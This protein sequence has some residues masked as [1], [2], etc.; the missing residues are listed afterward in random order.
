MLW[1]LL[2]DNMTS[3]SG[4]LFSFNIIYLFH[5]GYYIPAAAV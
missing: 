1:S 2:E 4:E 3:Q 5:V